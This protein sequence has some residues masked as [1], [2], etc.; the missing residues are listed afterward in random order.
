MGGFDFGVKCGRLPIRSRAAM[1]MGHKPPP[2]RVRTQDI[3]MHVG[4]ADR[5][6]GF[7]IVADVSQNTLKNGQRIMIGRPVAIPQYKSSAH[8]V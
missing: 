1:P 3:I 6:R 7:N 2:R 8:G 4:H 5:L